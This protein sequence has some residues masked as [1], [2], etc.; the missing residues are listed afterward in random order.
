MDPSNILNNILCIP[1]FQKTLN[2][3]WI[4]VSPTVLVQSE[5]SPRSICHLWQEVKQDKQRDSFSP[6][7]LSKCYIQTK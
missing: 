6:M 5:I 3:V 2:Q 7:K 4:W 1:H